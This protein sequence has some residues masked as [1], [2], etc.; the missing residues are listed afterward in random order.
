MN[1]PPSSTPRVPWRVQTTGTPRSR[2]AAVS[3]FAGSI[4]R[5]MCA[6]SIPDVAYQPSACRKSF[7]RS[8]WTSAVRPGAR[9]QCAA[10][11]GSRKSDIG[12]PIAAPPGLSRK[13]A[14]VARVVERLVDDDGRARLA[15]DVDRELRRGQ[16]VL[17]RQIR[18]RDAL[19]DD[20]AVA[21]G[22]DIADR[23]ALV[24]HGLV[25]VRVGVV[26]L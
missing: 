13:E 26:G 25:A 18:K 20:V 16:G 21:A 6:M 12:V 1:G 3:R 23:G 7:W 24:A 19:L 11:Y 9:S 5:C 15:Q 22:R 17:D 2:A 4:T 10:S 8:M 14:L